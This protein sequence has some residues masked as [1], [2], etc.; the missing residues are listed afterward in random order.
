MSPSQ[1]PKLNETLSFLKRNTIWSKLSENP[2]VKSCREAASNRWRLG[3]RGIPLPDELKTSLESYHDKQGRRGVVA[4]HCRGHQKIDYKKVIAALD[5]KEKPTKISE[6][7][8]IQE[9][10]MSYGEVT[11]FRLSGEKVIHLFDRSVFSQHRP[12]FSMMTNAGTHRRAIEFYPHELRDALDKVIIRDIVIDP[13]PYKPIKIGI[14]TGNG[15]ES[16]MLLWKLVN[17]KVREKLMSRKDPDGGSLKSWNTGGLALPK[18]LLLSEPGMEIS[19]EL[20]ERFEPTRKIVLD[21]IE[22]LCQGGVRLIAIACNTTQIFEPEIQEICKRFDVE[23]VSMVSAVE[24]VFRT[25]KV[26][27]FSFLGI[28]CVASL[29]KFSAFRKWKDEFNISQLPEK[30]YNEINEIAYNM[31]QGVGGGRSIQKLRNIISQN[32]K[33]TN[34]LIALTELSL[35]LA[36][37]KRKQKSKIQY[38]DTLDILADKV[39]DRYLDLTI[40]SPKRELLPER[41]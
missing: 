28:P 15:P 1:S 38:F 11:P 3:N 39:S 7:E 13:K 32:I 41:P 18:L 8:L 9:F 24:E 5:I 33:T 23:F 29:G 16:G 31:K 27:Q 26:Q 4:I 22:E 21:G 12:P 25:E 6:Q 20:E 17:D 30:E 36:S 37:Q 10:G 19:M 2:K 40:Q 35:V 34:V 14:L